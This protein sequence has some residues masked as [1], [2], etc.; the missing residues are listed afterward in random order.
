M[1]PCNM[2]KLD[3]IVRSVIGAATIGAGIYLNAYILIGLGLLPFMTGVSAFCPAYA[4]LGL[5]SG[6]KNAQ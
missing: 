5:N 1:L 3:R 2:G 4:L 6:C